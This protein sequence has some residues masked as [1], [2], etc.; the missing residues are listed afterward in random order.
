M[1]KTPLLFALLATSVLASGQDAADYDITF[2]KASAKI[3]LPAAVKHL[4][5]KT[6]FFVEYP[7]DLTY[8]KGARE[9]TTAH[10]LT[11]GM[12]FDAKRA[13]K[14]EEADYVFRI[15]TPGI[16]VATAEPE[17]FTENRK[18]T[19]F[20]PAISV[21]GFI[22]RIKYYMPVTLEVVNKQ[23]QVEKS[24]QFNVDTAAWEYHS[25]FLQD[26]TTTADWKPRKPIMPFATEKEAR[27]SFEKNAQ[28]VY[29]RMELNTWYYTLEDMKKVVEIGYSRYKLPVAD[30]YS[31]VLTKKS[32]AALPVIAEAVNRQQDFIGNLDDDKKSEAAMAGLKQN[33]LVFDSLAANLGSFGSKV[34]RVILSNAAW[35]ALISGQ[36]EKAADYFAKYYLVE[37]AEYEMFTPFK[38]AF[39]VYHNRDIISQP[40]SMVQPDEDVSFLTPEKPVFDPSTV[41]ISKEEGEVEKNDGEIIKG[42]IS[43]DFA[44]KAGGIVDMDLG[45]AATVYFTKNGGE[46]YQFAKVNNTKKIRIGNRTF[47]PVGRKTSVLLGA[48][49]AAAGDFSST[50]FMEKVYE[51]NGVVLYKFWAPA[52]VLLIKTKDEKAV[53]LSYILQQKK[54]ARHVFE[55]C[56]GAAEFIKSQGIKNNVED[57]RKLVD[58][59]GGCK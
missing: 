6:R 24:F 50:Y 1:R 27:E 5:E 58:F 19:Y 25:H 43:I 47:E 2:D 55:S 48:L 46:T 36:R 28:A 7:N 13:R 37:D 52:E 3:F 30:F 31:K 34:Q 32:K 11:Y 9:I 22:Y 29:K 21:K 51:K 8:L 20:A 14:A 53:D 10:E 4:D 18:A 26:V 33:M 41:N 39:A 59:L 57:A 15:S 49:N 38:T 23:G 40:A 56:T 16:R 42:K 45:K 35:G 17:Y 44:A 12:K 54:L